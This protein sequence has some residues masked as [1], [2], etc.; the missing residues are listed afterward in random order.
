MCKNIVILNWQR[1]LW[2]GDWE[3]VKRSGRDESIRVVIH[4]C[5]EAMLGISLY[6]YPLPRSEVG[7][8]KGEGGK[9]ERWPKQ[10]IHT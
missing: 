8:G 4:L 7:R 6:S 2:E 5:M 10:C 1:P 3:V 9:G